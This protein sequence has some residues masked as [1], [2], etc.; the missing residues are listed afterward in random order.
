[1]PTRGVLLAPQ[2][3]GAMVQDGQI[4]RGVAGTPARVARGDTF[5]LRQ[6]KERREH[7]RA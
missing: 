6:L 1:M 3:E 4:V 2:V 5:P 7:I